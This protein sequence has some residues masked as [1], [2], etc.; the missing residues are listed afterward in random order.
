MLKY[1]IISPKT[2]SLY[3]SSRPTHNIEMVS[4]PISIQILLLKILNLQG[5]R[6]CPIMSSVYSKSSSGVNEEKFRSHV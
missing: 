2:N 5:K 3:Y 1:S 4:D 6:G